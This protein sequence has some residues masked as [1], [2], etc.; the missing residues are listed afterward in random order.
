MGILSIKSEKP[1]NSKLCAG[2]CRNC[3]NNLT[4]D[5][6]E[7]EIFSYCISPPNKSGMEKLSA[8][9]PVMECYYYEEF[10]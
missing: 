7:G 3:I 4:T 2:L 6:Y 5:Y 10:E 8:D 9:K 1:D